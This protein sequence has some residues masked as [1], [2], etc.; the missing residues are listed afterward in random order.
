MKRQTTLLSLGD[1]YRTGDDGIY[2]M[3]SEIGNTMTGQKKGSK[4]QR[5]FYSNGFYVGGDTM[6]D[7]VGKVV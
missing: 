6:R 3:I 1:T 4:S 5:L 2:T 7:V